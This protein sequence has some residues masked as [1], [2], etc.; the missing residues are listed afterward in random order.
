[1]KTILILTFAAAAALIFTGCQNIRLAQ[2]PQPKTVV[3]YSVWENA[4]QQ[5]TPAK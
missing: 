4:V 3:P 5:E 1:M 2:N